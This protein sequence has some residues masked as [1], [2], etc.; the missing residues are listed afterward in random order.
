MCIAQSS[1]NAA[2]AVTECQKFVTR[3]MKVTFN[4]DLAL[5]E[6][7]IMYTDFLESSHIS[8]RNSSDIKMVFLDK[9]FPRCQVTP[10]QQQKI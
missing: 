6:R 5:W 8:H 10:Q 3:I 7:S 1:G 9:G 2:H 4:L